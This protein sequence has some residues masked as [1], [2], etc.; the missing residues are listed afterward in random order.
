M[1]NILS[2]ILS[3]LPIFLFCVLF[4]GGYGK[5]FGSENNT[6]GVA[7]LTALLMF[8]KSDFGYDRRQATLSLGGLLILMVVAPKLSL[9][10][11]YVGIFVNF[12]AIMTILVLSSY[13]V[14]K[15]NH[16]AFLLGYIF[17]QGYD[18]TGV[19]FTKRVVS[20]VI[21]AVIV[22]SIYL[23]CTRKRIYELKLKDVVKSLNIHQSNTQWYLKLASTLTVVMF[24]G[25]IFN[26]PR[27]VWINLAVLSLTYH[28]HEERVRRT[29]HR[30]PATIIGCMVFLIL[31]KYVI[32]ESMHG[33]AAMC[34][35]FIVMFASSYLKKTMGNSVSALV[36]SMVVFSIESAVVIRILSNTIGVAVSMLS[37]Y[38]F[39][40]IF[41]RVIANKEDIQSNYYTEYLD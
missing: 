5:L 28:Q 41:T 1:K 8:L 20:V 35:G 40:H 9:I 37:H 32:P 17:S 24:L 15:D 25:D 18:V 3:K 34:V 31:F 38:I 6:I 29:K 10:N 39:E 21:S 11:P 16:M 26:Y 14:E 22:C 27:I 13:N 33:M 2:V 30:L 23:L 12:F 36:A 4:I 7:I 19:L